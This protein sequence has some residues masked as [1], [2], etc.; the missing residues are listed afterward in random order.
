MHT[1]RNFRS[2]LALTLAL[3]LP[4]AML[5][6]DPDTP[7]EELG[8]GIDDV[9]DGRDTPAE[10]AAERI[11]DAADDVGEAVQEGAQNVERRVENLGDNDMN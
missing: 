2:L 3:G 1:L 11:E 9:L 6:C 8:E 5:G 4:F 7:A 10:N